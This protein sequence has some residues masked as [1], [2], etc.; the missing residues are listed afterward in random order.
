MPEKKST[1]TEQDGATLDAEPK[2]KVI[3]AIVDNRE[4][5]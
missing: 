5:W 1:T 2:P 3:M 4:V